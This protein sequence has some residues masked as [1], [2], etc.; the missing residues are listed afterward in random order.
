MIPVPMCRIYRR[1]SSA[2]LTLPKFMAHISQG[3]CKNVSK[4]VPKE[5]RTYHHSMGLNRRAVI[6]RDVTTMPYTQFITGTGHLHMNTS[7]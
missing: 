6:C 7:Q 2:P 3:G 4:K 5:K 1:N